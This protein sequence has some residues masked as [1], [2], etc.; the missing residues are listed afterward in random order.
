M[1]NKV[2]KNKIWLTYLFT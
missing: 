2:H 1:A